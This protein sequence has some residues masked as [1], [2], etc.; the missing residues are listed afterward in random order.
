MAKEFQNEN[1]NFSSKEL[2]NI[3]H[4]LNSYNATLNRQLSQNNFSKIAKDISENLARQNKMS[5]TIGEE[6]RKSLENGNFLKNIN[7]IGGLGRI[8]PANFPIENFAKQ[9]A[10][11]TL[12]SQL[13]ATNLNVLS[14]NISNHLDNFNPI[15]IGFKE[16]NESI[17]KEINRKNVWLDLES[18]TEINQ[19]L[20]EEIE[21]SGT[22]QV[23]DITELRDSLLDKLFLL[24]EKAKTEIGKEYIW[25]LMSL[26]SFVLTIYSSKNPSQHTIIHTKEIVKESEKG[27]LKIESKLDSLGRQLDTKNQ[28][29]IATTAVNLRFKNKKRSRKIGLVKSGQIVIVLKI[30]H[31]WLYISYVDSDT[32]EVHFGYV[33]KK[34]FDSI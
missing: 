19:E 3:S 10:E 4:W 34:H 18:I 33:Y 15:S 22:E 26:I 14:K 5:V 31:K 16:I 9:I 6:L 24:Y 23:I 11:F 12:G 20:V 29:R 27:L 1:F 7:A 25:R 17:Y 21:D 28:L 2:D 32:G 13:L 8:T 30:I